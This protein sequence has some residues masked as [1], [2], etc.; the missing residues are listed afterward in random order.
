M[1]RLLLLTTLLPFSAFACTAFKTT[2]GGRTL[3]GL[4][5]DAWSINA[6]VRFE[7]GRDGA[8]G[9]IYFAHYNG[10]PLREMSD[11]MGMNEAG[12]VF[13]GLVVGP[14][15]VKR[16]TGMPV[17][18]TS[19]AIRHVM[20]TCASVQEVATY[21]RSVDTGPLVGMLFFADAAGGYL[22]LEPDTLFTGNDAWYA[23]SNWRMSTCG[24][25]ATIPIPR[26]QAGRQLLMNDA[27]ASLSG[28]EEVLSTMAVCRPK[29]GE[30][31]L[32]SALFDPGEATAHLFFYHDFRERV[33]FDL[34]Q[35]LA[36]GDRTVDMA[37]LFGPRPEYERLE[38]CLTPFHQR[39]MFWILVSVLCVVVVAGTYCA[40]WF[41]RDAL[42]MIRKRPRTAMGAALLSGLLCVA[43][44]GL[45]S[46]LLMNE[47]PYYFGLGDV[48][49][50]LGWLPLIIIAMT[51][52]VFIIARRSSRPRWHMAVMA[53]FIVPVLGLLAYWQMLLP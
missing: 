36:K 43:L 52:G 21:L 29:L 8:Y 42:R 19:D 22:L 2:H 32:F 41:L 4:N 49:P 24:D 47:A 37:S 15:A 10:H 30:G 11:Q 20:R 5:E 38:R 53:L 27:G 9:G 18:A 33:T 51:A 25:P 7:Q 46:V 48:H 39:W 40:I 14:G 12:L 26:L 6:N 45:L 16:R 28:A 13:D 31:T 50:A 44:A 17:V 34:K 35:E 23:L 1:M 3:V